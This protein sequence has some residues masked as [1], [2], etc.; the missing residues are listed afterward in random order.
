MSAPARVIG[1][2]GENVG[3][4]GV[5]DE[6]VALFADVRVAAG[7]GDGVAGAEPMSEARLDQVGV[8]QV[9]LRRDGGAL[10]SRG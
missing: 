4:I 7:A 6:L 2:F 8:E 3:P 9:D 1:L 5:G 10:A